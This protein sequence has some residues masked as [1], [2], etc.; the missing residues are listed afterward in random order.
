MKKIVRLLSICLVLACCVVVSGCSCASPMKVSYSISTADGTN[1]EVRA[2]V[3]KKFREPVDTPCF[4]KVDGGK[5]GYSKLETSEEIQACFNGSIK[6]YKKV[7]D[8]LFKSKYVEIT[9]ILELNRCED[10]FDC[11]EK[12][13]VTYYKELKYPEGISECY[14]AEGEPFERATYEKA[15]SVELDNRLA[16]YPMLNRYMYESSIEQVPSNP[17]YSLIYTFS[18]ENKDSRKMYIEAIEYNVVTQ[19]I[20]KESSASKVKLTLPENRV[21]MNN[22]F[23]YVVEAGS[24]ITI[25]IEVKNLLTSDSAKKKTKELQLI[26]PLT[27]AY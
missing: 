8:G 7:K 6:C 13:D 18:V 4:K 20:V 21:F 25:K 5:S 26:I 14:N 1:M 15:E 17:N 10:E 12:A 2:I 23:Y 19:G 16:V 22:K 24:T 9:D 27:V 11:Y 3:T